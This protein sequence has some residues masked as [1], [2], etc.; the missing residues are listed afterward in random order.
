MKEISL[1][2]R[3]AK[4]SGDER[5]ANCIGTALFL[6]GE[7]DID[8]HIEPSH[9]RP[10]FEKLT[11]LHSPEVESIITWEE[12]TRKGISVGHAGLI[13]GVNPIL[14]THRPGCYEMNCN[15]NIVRGADFIE[16]D[17]MY[18]DWNSVNKYYR[19]SSRVII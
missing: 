12:S 17:K 3:L 11:E 13:V 2:D 10:Y 4:V 8:E 16:V 6:A 15:A 19:P 1:Q 7:V 14:I 18:K 9:S 5:P